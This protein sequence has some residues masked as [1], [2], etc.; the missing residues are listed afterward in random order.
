MKGYFEREKIIL[1]EK[2][3][4]QKNNSINK[5]YFWPNFFS[6]SFLPNF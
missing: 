2:N 5:F 6:Y 3:L 4:K 1:H